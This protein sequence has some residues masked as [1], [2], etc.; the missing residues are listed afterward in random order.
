M[1][2]AL[3][4]ILRENLAYPLR[5]GAVSVARTVWR[6]P[7]PSLA[8][9]VVLAGAKNVFAPVKAATVLLCVRELSPVPSKSSSRLRY[10]L[11]GVSWLQGIFRKVSRGA[12]GGAHRKTCLAED[13]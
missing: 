11:A 1:L 10:P 6:L 4:F 7:R 3:R 8:A 5:V 13:S 2:R 12:G 9:R